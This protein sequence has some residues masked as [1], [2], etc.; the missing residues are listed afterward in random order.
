MLIV[1]KMKEKSISIQRVKQMGTIM[2]IKCI[3]KNI[4]QIPKSALGEVGNLFRDG[5]QL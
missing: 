5:D 4:S 1:S 2:I 3:T